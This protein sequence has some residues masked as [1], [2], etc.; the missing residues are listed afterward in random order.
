MMPGIKELLD[1]LNDARCFLGLLTGNFEEGA[2]IK[3][4]IS[5]CGS[6]SNAVRSEGIR[7]IAT[8]SCRLRCRR[9]RAAVC[10]DHRRRTSWSSATRP[11]TSHAR[12]GRCSRP[13][14][15]RRAVPSTSS[16]KAVPTSFSRISATTTHSCELLECRPG[17]GPRLASALPGSMYRRK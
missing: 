12:S 14:A 11:T 2:R 6:T 15:W 8:R 4:R 9:A 1:A 17:L 13:S 10:A 5:T 7:R 16:G 3:L